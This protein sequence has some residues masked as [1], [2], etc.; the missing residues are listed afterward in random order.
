M[1]STLSRRKFLKGS[2]AMGVGA[3]LVTRPLAAEPEVESPIVNS[4]KRVKKVSIVGIGGSHMEKK[5]TEDEAIRIVRTALD[6]G[7]NFLDNCWDYNGGASE[8]RMGKALRDGYRQKAFLMSKI[9]GHSKAGAA[10]QIDESLGRLQTDHVDLMQFHEVIRPTDPESIFADGGSI[11]A[12]L[13]AQKSGKVRFIGSRAT[14]APISICTCSRWQR[15]TDFGSIPCRCHSTS[16]THTT[17]VL[18]QGS[19]R[20]Y[21]ARNR[22]SRHEA[23][24]QWLDFEEQYRSTGRV[25]SL[26]DESADQCGDYRL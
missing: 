20:P 16:W 12:M 10:R 7:I 18:E 6:S 23:N 3:R 26:C 22:C 15:V 1:H 25:P 19:A 2:V 11:E 8:I 21:R 4:G 5:P 13:E 9:D 17:K 14:R 24:G